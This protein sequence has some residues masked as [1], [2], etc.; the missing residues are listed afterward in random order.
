MGTI[1]NQ[2]APTPALPRSPSLSNPQGPHPQ[3]TLYHPASPPPQTPEPCPRR[4]QSVIL[5]PRIIP[6]LTK[7]QPCSNLK[8]SILPLTK[9]LLFPEQNAHFI[10]WLDFKFVTT[11]LQTF[12]VWSLPHASESASV[13]C[14]S[15]CLRPPHKLWLCL[16]FKRKGKPTHRHTFPTHLPPSRVSSLEAGPLHTP[17]TSSPLMS[18]RSL[19]C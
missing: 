5:S 14:S 9:R 7:P 3:T 11:D 15:S 19:L 2:A 12:L 16:L 1:P 18:P 8:S 13:S 4:C 10:D 6:R 17:W